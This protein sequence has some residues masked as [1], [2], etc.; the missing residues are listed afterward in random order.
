MGVLKSSK[1][2]DTKLIFARAVSFQIQATKK[3]L[4]LASWKR[5]TEFEHFL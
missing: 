3:H 2:I 1:Y 4:K 5:L